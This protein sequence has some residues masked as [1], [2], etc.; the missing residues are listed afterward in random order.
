MRSD[1]YRFEDH[2]AP[3][4]DIGL[5]PGSSVKAENRLDVDDYPCRDDTKSREDIHIPYWIGRPCRRDYVFKT[6]RTSLKEEYRI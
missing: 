6:L 2:D 3:L 1:C 5:T 4:S